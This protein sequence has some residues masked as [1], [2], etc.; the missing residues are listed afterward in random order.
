[1]RT[2]AIADELRVTIADTGIGIVPGNRNRVFEPFFTTKEAFGTGL[3]LWITKEI[4]EKHH[5][6]I[7][8]HSRPGRGTVFCIFLPAQPAPRAVAA[9]ANGPCAANARKQAS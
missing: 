4:I 2:A 7:R 3:G 9:I 6:R 5:G 1:L 8:M